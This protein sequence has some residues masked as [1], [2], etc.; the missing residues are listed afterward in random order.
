MRAYD[1]EVELALSDGVE[2]V[3]QAVP[4][5]VNGVDAV[6]GLTCRRTELGA[7]R[8]D[9]RP[10]VQVLEGSDFELDVTRVFRATGQVAD[11][12]FFEGVPD[13]A[14][15]AGKVVVDERFRTGNP[16]IWA[17]GDC[18]NGGKEVVNAVEHGKQAA[19]DIDA[20]LRS[21]APTGGN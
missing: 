16:R 19:R 5:A 12:D 3:P 9:G 11:Q 17:G 6:A 4:V 10:S 21:T 15:A 18:V 7:P 2:L 1:H 14:L 13:V 20:T 8:P